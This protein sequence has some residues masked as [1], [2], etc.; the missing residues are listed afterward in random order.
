[1]ANQQDEYNKSYAQTRHG[2]SHNEVNNPNTLQGMQGS[3]SYKSSSSTSGCFAAKTRVLTASGW[4][5]IAT[6]KRGDR[7]MSLERSTGNLVSCQVLK[8]VRYNA[9]QL[10][11]VR[12]ASGELLTTTRNHSFL[13]RRGWTTTKNLQV[14]EELF[15]VN[16]AGRT[17]FNSIADVKRTERIEP[18]FNLRTGGKFNFIAEGLVAH[19]FTHMRS[20]RMAGWRFLEFVHGTANAES[21]SEPELFPMK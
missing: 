9:T 16:R 1:M 17:T 6:L 2:A 13:T 15:F 10:W 14:G 18:V 5:G 21:V 20:L 11:D 8:L 4:S 19:N 3:G 12:L 7:V